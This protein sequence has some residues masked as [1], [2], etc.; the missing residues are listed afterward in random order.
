MKDEKDTEVLLSV[1][2]TA[3]LLPY[4]PRKIWQML[5]EGVFTRVKC[6]PSKPRSKTRI[7]LSEVLAYK[8]KILGGSHAAV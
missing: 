5:S 6:D 4:K 3:Q 2:E 8:S 1:P 7:R